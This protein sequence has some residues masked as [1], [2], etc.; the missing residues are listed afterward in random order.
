VPS[1]TLFRPVGSSHSGCGDLP[2]AKT[3]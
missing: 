2:P 3:N 1:H